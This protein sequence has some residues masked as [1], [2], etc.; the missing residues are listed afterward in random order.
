VATILV[1]DDRPSNRQYLTTLLGYGGH[2]M[3]EAE[4]GERALDAVRAERPALVITDI[5]MPKMDG[6]EFV[7]RMRAE[8]E[9]AATPVIF[10]TATYSTPQAEA[11]ARSC[12]VRT[13]LSKPCEPQVMLA[14]VNRELGV[15]DQGGAALPAA[16][17]IQPG[18]AARQ[19]DD[20]LS[21]FLK[22]LDDVKRRFEDMAAQSPK[23]QTRRDVV[24]ELSR[25]FAENVASMQR[26]TTRL[27]ALLEVGMELMSERDPRRLVELFFAATCDLIDSTYAAVGMLDASERAIDIVFAKGFDAAIVRG[28]GGRAGLLGSLLSGQRT[29]RA[30]VAPGASGAQGLPA[31]HPKTRNLLGVPV[32]S[33][34]RVYGW[35]Y[36]ADKRGKGGFTEEDMRLLNAMSRKL[37]LLY[38][39][40]MLYDAVQRNSAEL[41]IEVSERRRAQKDL[42]ERDAALHRA[43]LIA[44][45]AHVVTTADGS[46]ESW[47]E[48][49]PQM[50]GLRADAMPR[51]TR[52]WLE[53]VHPEDRENFRAKSIETGK[54]GARFEC[55]YRLKRGENSWIHIRQVSEP[56]DSAG[57][58]ADQRR[59][60]GTLQDVTDQ[61]QA[62]A[63]LAESEARFRSLST[64]SS[65]WFWEQDED[66]RFVSFSGGGEVKGWGPDQSKAIGL[67]RWDL[68]GVIPISCSWEEHKGL[69]DAHKPFR[70][71]EYQRVLADGRLQYV[72][73]SGVPGRF[74]GYHGVA[75]EI[76]GRK[77]AALRIVRLNRVYA[78]LSGINALNVRA[79]DREELFRESCRIAVEQGG[80]GMAWIG[81]LDRATLDVTPVAWHGMDEGAASMKASA[82]DDIPAG[83]GMVGQAIRG[84]APV[85]TNDINADPAAGGPRRAEALRKGF[86]SIIAMPLM[87]DDEVRA[88][89]TLFARERNFFSDDEMKLL[90][91]LAGDISFALDHIEKA[92]KLDYLAYYDS[93]TGLAN[94]TLFNERL[95]QYLNI[96]QQDKGKIALVLADV[97]RFKTINDSL[98]RQSGDALLK[99]VAER[100]GQVIRPANVGRI[101][102][103]HFAIVLP[104]VRGRSEIARIVEGI[105]KD[106]F[107]QPFRVNGTELRIAAKAGIAHFPSDGG[108]AE[109]L[110]TSAEAALAKAQQT[111]ERYQFHS[112]ELTAGTSGQLALENRLRQAMEKDE[113]ILH[114]QPKVDLDSRRIVGVEALIRWQNPELGL[115]P[116]LKFIPLM[117]ETGLILDV[118]A[119]ALTRAVADH[120]QWTGQ[121]LAAPRIAVNVSAIQLRRKDF[122]AVV[123]Q[124]L[125][126]GAM[127]PGIDL[128]I[129]ESLLME[130]VEASIQK[131]KEIRKIGLS[132]GIDD[133]GTGYSSLAYLAKLP[134]ATLKIDRAFIIHLLD[135]PDSATLVQTMISLAHTLNLKVVAEG[136]ETEEQA[137]ILRLLKCDQM[138]GYLFSKPLP[139]DAMT[140]LLLKAKS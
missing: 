115:V 140:A 38:E 134:L 3:L 81:V 76:T 35:M 23:L 45:L 113:F 139:L 132:I 4:D 48:T 17:G 7:Q 133:F 21:L 138:Q 50:L 114:Y 95:T 31:G 5:L 83:L 90:T 106:C 29:I 127:P 33:T 126:G 66:H 9:F 28:D 121:G 24:S 92:E 118:G 98:G 71:F 91:E 59:W 12:G 34:D 120:A 43:Q 93:L 129:T 13:V 30:R 37:A 64:L 14:A 78:V 16:N 63:A 1:V 137:K 68:G 116:P 124:A 57:D 119:W 73:A 53:F 79:R 74:T 25:K 55:E 54:T 112:H 94:R 60:F 61:K 128:E 6:Y 135:D 2:R 99:Q 67:H 58:A 26:V 42:H 18:A 123:E 75:T 20:T 62:T 87:V 100:M 11:L 103:D 8:P 19:P 97:E 105:L 36:F 41:Q 39:N 122:V 70:N 89:L 86:Q 80:F 44:K 49:L 22:D 130:D 15:S 101:G 104:G 136:V 82:R 65:D 84:K 52:E 117:E 102:G 72:E 109:A 108:D 27:S 107:A 125:K 46:F 77:E 69:L 51:D 85:T 10:Y 111:G 40:A 131:L 56:L 32:A 96:A 47:S 88:T 110:F